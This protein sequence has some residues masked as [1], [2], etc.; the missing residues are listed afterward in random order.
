MKGKAGMAGNLATL[1][2]LETRQSAVQPAQVRWT[3]STLLKF[4]LV[5]DGQPSTYYIPL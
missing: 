2:A 5:G 1:S 3:L 4:G